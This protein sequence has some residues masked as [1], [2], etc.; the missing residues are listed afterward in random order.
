MALFALLCSNLFIWN[1][2]YQ[3]YSQISREELEDFLNVNQIHVGMQKKKVPYEEL[4]RSLRL[5]FDVIKWANVEISGNTLYIQIMENELLTKEEETGRKDFETDKNQYRVMV[6]DTDAVVWSILVR[7]G[8]PCVKKG[9]IVVTGQPLIS[10]AVPIIG[11][12]LLPIGYQFYEPDGDVVLEYDLFFQTE[13]EKSILEKVYTGRETECVFIKLGK[14][15]LHSPLFG[16]YAYYDIFSE[17]K[18]MTS[19]NENPLPVFYG[20]YIK[21]EYYIKERIHSEEE[22]KTLLTEKLN[23]YMLTLDEKGVQILQK[24]VKISN[25]TYKWYMDVVFHVRDGTRTHITTQKLETELDG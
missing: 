12:D 24:D 21:R 25:D 15:T 11:D 9:D 20:K 22:A 6:A 18:Q 1:I 3:G 2:R 14:L 7:N 17:T 13:L 4:E 8:V 19:I 5:E 16:D 23:A 10:G